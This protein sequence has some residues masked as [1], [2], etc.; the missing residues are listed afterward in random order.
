MSVKNSPTCHRRVIK[1][2]SCWWLSQHDTRR[3]I[4]LS[5]AS[6]LV[7]SNGM[8][9]GCDCWRWQ[10]LQ[11]VMRNLMR[12]TVI[13]NPGWNGGQA[14]PCY[15]QPEPSCHTAL[16]CRCL[17]GENMPDTPSSHTSVA[18]PRLPFPSMGILALPP[19]RLWVTSQLLTV[20]DPAFPPP[21]IQAAWSAATD[22]DMPACTYSFLPFL[23]ITAPPL[24][25]SPSLTL[26]EQWRCTC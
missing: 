2:L 5:E 15:H 24:V 9:L 10:R 4:Q 25:C 11:V 6:R 18:L 22:S 13:T 14:W 3:H 21:N 12:S 23:T 19:E 26:C 1:C 17:R 16:L 7:N 8:G 20:S